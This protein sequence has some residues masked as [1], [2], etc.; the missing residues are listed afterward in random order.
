MDGSYGNLRLY[1]GGTP[2]TA[3][4]S[5]EMPSLDAGP[6]PLSLDAETLAAR[7]LLR[8]VGRSRP[9][10]RLEP[11]S[12]AWYDELEQKRYAR[13]GAWLPAALEFGRHPGESVLLVNPGVGSDAVRYLK[14]GSEVTVLARP[15]DEAELVRRNLARVGSAAP[16]VSPPDGSV[17]FT[18]G[19]FDIVVVNALYRPLPEAA[20]FADELF[21]VLKAGGK[22]IGLFPAYYDAGF[23]QDRL[24]PYQ[25]LYWTRPADPTTAP[26]TTA[27]ELCRVFAR[28]AGHR[29]A[30]RH[31]R[32]GELPHACRIFPLAVLERL[33]GR[34]LVLKAFKPI[35]A[36]R[37]AVSPALPP[38][39]VAA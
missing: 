34:V 13:H 6:L 33:F 36:A 18:G 25:R 14:Q 4:P 9:H 35:S 26:K 5:A 31:L 22:A 28:F 16:V 10:H 37:T 2:A 3:D 17:P 12:A 1:P 27:R 21:R 8:P 15:G 24:L 38:T 11:Y 20:A 30:R 23:W 7:E 39:S 32:R 19:S 29:V